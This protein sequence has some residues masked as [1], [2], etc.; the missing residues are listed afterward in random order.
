M[1]QYEE[2]NEQNRKMIRRW[3][4]SEAK[5]KN[6]R[7]NKDLQA[8]K[9]KK[10][11]GNGRNRRKAKTD[12]KE[13]KEVENEEKKNLKIMF[14]N[15]CGLRLRDELACEQMTKE[16][17][18]IRMMQ[19]TKVEF[20]HKVSLSKGFSMFAIPAQVEKG[21][22]GGLACIMTEEYKERVIHLNDRSAN[23][24]W[25]RVVGETS[26]NEEDVFV[27]NV[28]IPPK[29]RI[30]REKKRNEENERKEG[31]EAGDTRREVMDNLMIEIE[32]YRGRGIVIVGGDFNVHMKA[33]GDEKEDKEGEKLKAFAEV[34]EL[35]IVNLT[36]ACS[37]QFTWQRIY[38]DRQVKTG[39]DADKEEEDDEDE[40]KEGDD[41]RDEEK[42][43]EERNRKTKIRQSTLDYI[44]VTKEHM[45]RIQ[46]MTIL[47]KEGGSLGSDHNPIVDE[48]SLPHHRRP[49]PT[50]PPYKPLPIWNLADINE[51]QKLRME[52]S[53]QQ[54][55]E[56]E[57]NKEV[58]EMEENT[59]DK[60][61]ILNAAT[62]TFV[63]AM[64]K[65]T[66]EVVGATIP[67][68]RPSPWVTPHLRQMFAERDEKKEELTQ[69]SR[70][71]EDEG[72]EWEKKVDE[73]RELE[74]KVKKKI[75][76][77]KREK[78]G[79]TYVKA[80]DRDS[81]E[82]RRWAILHQ[83]MG[84]KSSTSIAIIK[85][86]EG[87]VHNTEEGKKTAMK[88]YQIELG[89][90]DDDECIQNMETD[91]VRRV[92][93]AKEKVMEKL[94]EMRENNKNM[95]AELDRNITLAEVS[96]A[97]KSLSS[98][99][100]AGD[101]TMKGEMLKYGGDSVKKALVRL[102]NMIMETETWPTQ[103]E[104]GIITPIFKGG[105][106]SDLNDYRN[107]TVLSVLSKVFEMIMNK[108]LMEWSEKMEKLCDEQGGFRPERGCLDQVFILNEILLNRKEKKKATITAFI[109]VKKAYDKVWRDG[110]WVK[111]YEMGVDG[112]VWRILQEMYKKVRRK[113]KIGEGTTD[114]FEVEV[115]VAQGSVLSPFLYSCF[116]N[117]LIKRM[118]ERG[119]GI[120]IAGEK[121]AILLYADDI[122]LMMENN[123][124]MEE[125]LKILDE[126][127]SEWQFQYNP[128]KSKI[129]VYGTK[130]QR[131]EQSKSKRILKLGGVQLE[132]VQEYKYLG[133]KM[134]RE[135][136]RWKTVLNSKIIKAEQVMRRAIV[137]GFRRGHMNAEQCVKIWKGLIRP[138]LEYG[139]EVIS[140]DKKS[141]QQLE[142][143]QHK[144][145]CAILG[146]PTSASATYVRCELGLV[147][148]A[149]RQDDLRLRWRRRLATSKENRILH[150]IWV[151]RCEQVREMRKVTVKQSIC[152][153]L[154]EV[155]I[156]H[157]FEDEW[158]D[159]KLVTE[160][161]QGGWEKR[162]EKAMEEH[163]GNIIES[164]KE[165]NRVKL[166][167]QMERVITPIAG[168]KPYLRNANR[169]DGVWLQTRCRSNML[170]V[171]DVIG[172]QQ[173]PV[174]WTAEQRQCKH[175]RKGEET[176]LH[177]VAE[178]EAYKNERKRFVDTVQQR[179]KE[180]CEDGQ[181]IMRT[182]IWQNPQTIADLAMAM[183]TT[184]MSENTAANINRAGMNYLSC[185]WK[186]R[187]RLNNRDIEEE[188]VSES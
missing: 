176:V 19:E 100:A 5:N 112:K 58:D 80:T 34:N 160:I 185:I 75:K 165:E 102:Y 186:A 27:A 132:I 152:A 155:M 151:K 138:I 74:K 126:Y 65:A 120:E 116:I 52:S 68:A 140:G 150:K 79:K 21:V 14:H 78:D 3:N 43:E 135:I 66:A 159:P 61:I 73:L 108:R 147:T 59:A 142:T 57:W 8:W 154:K 56:E 109:D 180:E 167:E 55:L 125:A 141:M 137:S 20:E 128:K 124:Q 7:M 136:A 48:L 11:R 33:N 129:V 156:R 15:I 184:A 89:K 83:I 37:G 172:R 9:R 157:G 119:I 114:E 62:A 2:N 170:R 113:V 139:L 10:Q 90:K 162:I 164:R 31:R 22:R 60:N 161:T 87:T 46:R 96:N 24:Q 99:K 146:L 148:I 171:R 187:H 122:V 39:K 174:I 110:L 145:G 178:C 121:I 166:G 123:K 50:S 29:S 94:K 82:R 107:I 26:K 92:R 51:E 16:E 95:N 106:N 131:E 18:S 144:M 115:G 117:G 32:K 104:L 88:R 53:T 42:K 28:Y 71:K 12:R 41:R 93:E 97:I 130:Q 72:E 91:E 86:K 30:G 84:T 69:M 103:W 98:G 133:L 70:R 63:E 1:K 149:T 169:G 36:P 182:L 173:R 85:D 35:I 188:K 101:D 13:G 183:S 67:S 158:N 40:D 143:V 134:G 81:S 118:K 181:L 44:L 38:E 127:A 153:K 77:T 168:F 6:K 23:V 76:E 17:V 105:D 179:L 49:H 45:S 175:C 111:M 163:E 25:V 47:N 54:R 177:L 4:E 64:A